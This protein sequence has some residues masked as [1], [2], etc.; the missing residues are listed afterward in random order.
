MCEL[1]LMWADL[2]AS[3]FTCRAILS[4]LLCFG[5]E[6]HCVAQADFK[7]V[8]PPTSGSRMLG[9]QVCVLFPD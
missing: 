7:L 9:L 8:T 5:I 6:S 3:A 4:A 2:A 1:Y